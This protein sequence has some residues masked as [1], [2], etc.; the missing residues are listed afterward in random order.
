MIS[1]RDADFLVHCGNSGK[2]ACHKQKF[3]E[4]SDIIKNHSERT[5]HLQD[6]TVEDFLTVCEFVYFGSAQVNVL[7][8]PKISHLCKVLGIETSLDIIWEEL[9]KPPVNI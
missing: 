8:I 5:L 3:S 1:Y 6:T 4:K 9:R 2:V 7:V